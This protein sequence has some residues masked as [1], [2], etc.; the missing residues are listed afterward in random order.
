MV[1]SAVTG[2]IKTLLPK[3]TSLLERKYKLSRGVRRQITSLRHEM[4]SMSALLVRLAALEELDAQQKDWRDKVRELSYDIEDCID[5]FTNELDSDEAK[6]GGLRR[7][8]KK[9]KSRYKI[10]HRIEE[11]RAQVVELSN[12]QNRYKIDECLS[13]PPSSRGLVD[14][15]PRLEALY[16]NPD[17]LVGI[18]AQKEKLIELLRMDADTQQLEVVAIAGFG[19]MGKTTLANQVYTKIKGQFDCTAFVSVSRSPNMAKILSDMI[20]GISG[21]VTSPC[22]DDRQLINLLRSCLHDRRYLIVIDDIWTMEAWNAIKCSF[23]ENSPGSRVIATTRFEDIAKAC[24]SCFHGHVYRIKPLN[25]LDSRRLFD[26][27]VFHFE[28]ACPEKLKNVR[29]EILSKCEG[30]PL[31]ILS[32]ASILASH[33]ELDSNE[34]WEKVHKRLGFHL[35]RHPA[36]GWIRHVLN[37]GYNDLCLDLKTCLIYF[38]IF[39]ESSEIMKNDLVKRWLADGFVTEKHGYG[40]HEIAESYFSE[41]INRNMIQIAKFDDCGHVL[42]CRVHDIML[43]FI[44][45]K[46]T[47]ENFVTIMNDV[48]STKG[49][50]EVRRLSLEVKNS[51]CNHLLEKMS[52]TQARSFTFRGPAE[53]M[54]CVS[55]FQL[56]R[57]LHISDYNERAEEFDLSGICN[58]FQLKYLRIVCFRGRCAEWLKQLRKLQHLQTLEIVPRYEDNFFLDVVELPLALWHLIIPCTARLV[59]DIGRMRSLI[60]VDTLAIHDIEGMEKMRGLGNLTNLREVELYVSEFVWITDGRYQ[61]PPVPRGVILN[62]HFYVPYLNGV[63]ICEPLLSSLGM[64]GSLQSLIIHGGLPVDVLNCWSPPPCH[65]RRLH[66]RDCPFS[67][68]PDWITQLAN[69]RSLDIQVGSI[70]REGIQ[71]LAQLASLVNLR[72]HVKR[73]LPG[74]GVVIPGGV[75]FPK[76]KD[77]FFQCKMLCLVFEAGAMPRLEN[78]TVEC[79]SQAVRLAV[80]VLEGIEHLGS[81]NRCKVNI[82]ER[83]DFL[84]TMTGGGS[85][86]K[87][88]IRWDMQTLEDAVRQ[89]INKHLGYHLEVTVLIL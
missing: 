57:V 12:C 10:A 77:L 32:V 59:G 27:R 64:L 4:S 87:P 14:I 23:L 2:S 16:V 54:P 81:L 1:A 35:E 50:L 20:L 83:H 39:P 66:V 68:V 62:Q 51:E 3:L 89:A 43:D 30:V 19:G 61:G 6:R 65:L 38:S 80:G 29:E 63:A 31:V 60:S 42:S 24:C 58:L 82:Y 48:Q 74:E 70:T 33:E 17:R 88:P 47:E 75:A 71:I 18:H 45:L 53:C 78:L 36:L 11:L 55:V 46:S 72:L 41:L 85:G 49:C 56:L 84:P 26:R 34:I 67:S 73:Y 52:L 7:R 79:Y 40:P 86:P 44:I 21:L 37:L 9:I 25:G 28:D 5:I 22:E 15:D 8:L 76:L 69:L 13:C